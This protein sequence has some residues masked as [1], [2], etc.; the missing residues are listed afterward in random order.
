MLRS[1]RAMFL[2][3]DKTGDTRIHIQG[4][5]HIERIQELLNIRTYRKRFDKISPR[6][7]AVLNIDFEIGLDIPYIAQDRP[8]GYTDII[9][10][11]QGDRLPDIAGQLRQ[12]DIWIILYFIND[13]NIPQ[14]TMNLGHEVNFFL[15]KVK[16]ISRVTHPV[17]INPFLCSKTN[18][19]EKKAAQ[20]EQSI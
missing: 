5:K 9:Y 15:A 6:L 17:T 1:P 2:G 13:Q 16:N 3:K 12:T 14:K 10:P 20:T 7:A 11:A 4:G 8:T 18:T 19:N